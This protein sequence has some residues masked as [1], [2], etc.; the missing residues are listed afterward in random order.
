[1]LEEYSIYIYDGRKGK[2]SSIFEWDEWKNRVARATLE[3]HFSAPVQVTISKWKW[4]FC[5]PFY[6]SARDLMTHSLQR[7]RGRVAYLAYPTSTRE[8]IKNLS[9][10]TTPMISRDVYLET[11][12]SRSK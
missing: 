12:L 4:N 5:P 6:V 1:M 7:E 10:W 2:L 3:E 11:F 8:L 9:C